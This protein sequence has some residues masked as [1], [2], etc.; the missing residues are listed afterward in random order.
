ML[1]WSLK[2]KQYPSALP[3]PSPPTPSASPPWKGLCLLSHE[4]QN[5]QPGNKH[6]H[7][8]PRPSLP[9]SE[10]GCLESARSMKPHKAVE[11]LQGTET[12]LVSSKGIFS[13][14]LYAPDRAELRSLPPAQTHSSDLYTEAGQSGRQGLVLVLFLVIILR[15]VGMPCQPLLIERD[16]HLGALDVGFL[17]RDQVGLVRVLPTGQSRGA[18]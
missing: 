6:L 1:R 4:P 12:I 5:G 11:Q 18:S 17:G 7:P 2:N 15:G 9:P 14:H 3:F 8:D 13:S 10:P 16:H